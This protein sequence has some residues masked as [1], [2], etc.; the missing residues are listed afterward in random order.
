MRK[1]CGRVH[2]QY[3]LPTCVYAGEKHAT[4]RDADHLGDVCSSLFLVE[5]LPPVDPDNPTPNP[6]PWSACNV[7]H[8]NCCCKRLKHFGN[9]PHI[10]AINHILM[11][12]N[13]RYHL[14]SLPVRSKGGNCLAPPPALELM[15]HDGDSSDEEL[16]MTLKL[17]SKGL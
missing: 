10:L 5:Q 17:G 13:V 16:E 3:S 11:A 2:T 14:L 12:F 1:V 8:L 15:F 4:I 6:L 7:A 9:C